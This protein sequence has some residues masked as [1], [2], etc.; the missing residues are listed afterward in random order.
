MRSILS[1]GTAPAQSVVGAAYLPRTPLTVAHG[2]VPTL[3]A[4]D[5]AAELAK[6]VRAMGNV[7]PT[8]LAGISIILRQRFLP[9]SP[10]E[11]T[12]VPILEVRRSGTVAAI[13]VQIPFELDPACPFV[14]IRA[15]ACHVPRW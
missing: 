7:W 10:A 15:A 11:D 4:Q 6:P 1:R 13:T 3:F 2:Q 8:T 14:C 5:I 9:S 12:A